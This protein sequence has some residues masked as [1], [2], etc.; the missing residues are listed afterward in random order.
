M[1]D[2]LKKDKRFKLIE[3]D[4]GEIYSLVVYFDESGNPLEQRDMEIFNYSMIKCRTC[5]KDTHLTKQLIEVKLN[6]KL[7]ILNIK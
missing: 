5:K 2:E 6:N 7:S 1:I 4:L 3:Q